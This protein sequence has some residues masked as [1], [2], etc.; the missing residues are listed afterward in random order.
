V[1]C[2]KKNIETKNNFYNISHSFRRK[3]IFYKFIRRGTNTSLNVAASASRDKNTFY[4]FSYSFWEEKIFFII[5]ATDFN[6][7]ASA[8]RNNFYKI[9]FPTP[10]GRK[11]TFYNFTIAEPKIKINK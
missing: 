7:A 9:N 2:G 6:V 3:N 4:N 10:S 11:N 5:G 1:C 8:F